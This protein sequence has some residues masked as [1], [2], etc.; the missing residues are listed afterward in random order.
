[1]TPVNLQSLAG[2]PAVQPVLLAGYNP[3]CLVTCHDV[4][5]LLAHSCILMTRC[6]AIAWLAYC[7]IVVTQHDV[8]AMLARSHVVVTWCNAL[9]L[10][11]L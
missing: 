3:I 8:L 10:I 7:H 4:H 2:M 5:V 11:E 9:A 6:N 1:M